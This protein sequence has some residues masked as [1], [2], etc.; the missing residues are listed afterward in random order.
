M[1]VVVLVV[2][3]KQTKNLEKK[4]TAQL[5]SLIAV[6][7]EDIGRPPL[8]TSYVRI[9]SL[10]LSHADLNPAEHDAERTPS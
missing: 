10:S 6:D 8:N 1:E 2:V 9:Q 4:K 7:P 5:G 3:K